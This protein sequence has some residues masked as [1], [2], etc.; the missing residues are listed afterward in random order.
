MLPNAAAPAE[1]DDVSAIAVSFALLGNR[2][3]AFEHL[4]KAFSNEDDELI[5]GNPLFRAGPTSLRSPLRGPDAPPR[6]AGIAVSIP[7]ACA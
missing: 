6:T 5:F 2:D 7:F 4:E 3:K 1:D